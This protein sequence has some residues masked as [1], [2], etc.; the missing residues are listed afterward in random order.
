MVANDIE[1]L[2]VVDTSDA[3]FISKRGSSQ[4]IK[5]IV[6]I[7]KKNKVK[8]ATEHKQTFRPWGSYLLLAGGSS[9]QVKRINVNPGSSLS[10]QKHNFRTEHWIIVSGKALVEIDKEVKTLQKNESTYIPLGSKHRLSNP[11]KE[12]LIIIEVQSG[13][14]LGEDDIVRFEDIYG[15]GNISN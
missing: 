2:I 14:Y 12:P 10:L 6:E 7:L 1:D 3:I 9:W 15:R 4:K 5:N 13:T 8:E 11:Y